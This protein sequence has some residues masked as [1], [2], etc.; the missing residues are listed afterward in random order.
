MSYDSCEG[1][2]WTNLLKEASKFKLDDLIVAIENYLIEQQEEWVQQN[3]VT[4]HKFALSNKLTEQTSGLLQSN[5]GLT[6]RHYPQIQR[7]CEFTKRDLDRS[8]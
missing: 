7:Y 2:G 8:S 1:I 6:T 4:I 3:I 5:H